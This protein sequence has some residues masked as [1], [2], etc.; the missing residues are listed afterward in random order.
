MSTEH[1]QGDDSV[2][3]DLVHRYREAAAEL[4]ERPSAAAR[5]AILAAAAREVN[6]QPVVAGTAYRPRRAR[7][8]LAAAAVVMLSTLA[9]MLAIRTQ[10]E[11]PQFG[12]PA[13][14]AST[15][16]QKG[17][18]AATPA[19]QSNEATSAREQQSGVTSTENRSSAARDQASSP[20]SRREND[21]AAKVPS[22]R[23]QAARTPAPVTAPANSMPAPAPPKSAP[24]EP[25]A[26]SS[27]SSLASSKLEKAQAEADAGLRESPPDQ[28][29]AAAPT[30]DARSDAAGRAAPA[31]S[32]AQERKRADRQRADRQSA[33]SSESAA[34]WLE[35]IIRLRGAGRHSEADAELKRFRERYPQIQPPLEALPAAGAQ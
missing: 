6:A 22:E 4:D 7:W 1:R 28:A 15:V 35:R 17:A 23:E 3:R 18:P 8:P 12:A 19:S 24:P 10:E 32:V 34:A 5:E 29:G 16:T 31:P 9:V 14:E 11:M 25:A 26:P 2:D 27:E 20:Q 30:P 13:Q 33:E 21:Q